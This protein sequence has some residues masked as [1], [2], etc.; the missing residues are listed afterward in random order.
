MGCLERRLPLKGQHN[1]SRQFFKFNNNKNADTTKTSSAN[2][3]GT[4]IVPGLLEAKARMPW[5]PTDVMAV[6][7]VGNTHSPP[8][9][10]KAKYIF[11]DIFDGGNPLNHEITIGPTTYL[12]GLLTEC[13]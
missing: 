3:H 6:Q 2:S 12:F 13:R 9:K 1:N 10:N 11:T 4:C 8:H 5:S 7:F